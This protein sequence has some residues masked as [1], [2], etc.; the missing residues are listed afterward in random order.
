MAGSLPLAGQSEV[1]VGRRFVVELRSKLEAHKL[2]QG[3]EFEARTVEALRASDGRM[4]PRGKQPLVAMATGVLGERQVE[5]DPGREGEIRAD[6]NRGRNAAIGALVVGGMGAAVGAS[7]S[8]GKG[9]ELVLPE[10]ARIELRL[11]RPLVFH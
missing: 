7:R 3:K 4:T 9:G 6:S 5:V 8:G 1:P 2:K 11:D 10:G